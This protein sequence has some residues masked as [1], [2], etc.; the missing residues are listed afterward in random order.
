MFYFV[1]L[2]AIALFTAMVL[3]VMWRQTSASVIL[4]QHIRLHGEIRTCVKLE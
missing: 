3:A 4:P 1:A 2:E